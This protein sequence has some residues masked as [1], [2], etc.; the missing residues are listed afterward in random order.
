MLRETAKTLSLAK[1]AP[2]KELLRSRWGRSDLFENKVWTFLSETVLPRSKERMMK[3]P[4]SFSTAATSQNG[5]ERVLRFQHKREP[6]AIPL[7]RSNKAVVAGTAYGR[8]KIAKREVNALSDEFVLFPLD[9][10]EGQQSS[11]FLNRNSIRV[12][13]ALL[14]HG[15][16]KYTFTQRHIRAEVLAPAAW[17]SKRRENS[18][19][20]KLSVDCSDTR[21]CNSRNE[22]NAGL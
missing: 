12:A 18:M 7:G 19:R 4:S 3:F 8:N 14:S 5:Q 21:C 22:Y 16:N 1:L 20:S 2:K 15:C 11:L 6:N 10:A 13:T 17:N 9:R